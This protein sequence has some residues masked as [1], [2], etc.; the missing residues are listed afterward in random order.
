[1][2]V[3]PFTVRATDSEGSYADRQFNIT[4]RNS[5]VERFMALTA[6]DAWTSPDG[7][8]WT[9]RNGAGGISCEYGNGFWLILK[10]ANDMSCF[11]S[12]DGIN[13]ATIN[14]AD[15][16]FLDSTGNS[17]SGPTSIQAKSCKLKFWN[18]KF[19]IAIIAGVSYALY[20][21]EDGITWKQ[22][23][24][25]ADT[26]VI[27]S[28][29]MSSSYLNKVYMTEDNGTLFI[30]FPFNNTISPDS[31]YSA[32][33]GWS[34]TDGVTFTLLTDISNTGTGKG[35]AFLTR[36][37]GLYLTQNAFH[38]N[39]QILT[40]YTYSTD[41]L[42]WTLQSYGSTT[43][44]I[45]SSSAYMESGFIYVNGMLYTI[46]SKT[47]GVAAPLYYYTSNDGLNWTENTMKSFLSGSCYSQVMFKNGLFLIAPT[48][49][50][51]V[52]ETA[53][54]TKPNNGIRLSVDGTNW[55]YVNEQSGLTMAYTDIAA[56]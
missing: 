21:T 32:G 44:T 36:V 42:N 50:Q 45:G 11:K 22:H 20:S 41:G 30:P 39:S 14:A 49:A 35:S 29:I 47:T 18:G 12:T 52:D 40:S 24:L 48:N 1:M 19:W 15:M 3:F 9:Q 53:D 28:K 33:L 34:T 16:I 37:N 46:T 31:G 56:M 8:T 5:R 38:N 4:V 54:N 23:I 7:T 27:T 17:I 25:Y 51:G 26:N 10:S 55:S 2:A 13:Y 6:T 43:P